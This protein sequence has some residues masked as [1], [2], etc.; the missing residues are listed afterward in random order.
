MVKTID[1][2]GNQCWAESKEEPIPQTKF[3][4]Y[5]D[6]LEFDKKK[7]EETQLLLKSQSKNNNTK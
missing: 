7:L 4:N 3:N 5:V 6:K 1:E 2:Y